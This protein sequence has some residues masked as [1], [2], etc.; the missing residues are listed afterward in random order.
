[1]SV[2]GFIAGPDGEMDWMVW[3]WDD[4]LKD[5]VGKITDTVDCIILGR[6][7]AEGFIP[8]WSS[9]PEEEG[10]E[11]I[12]SLPKIVFSKTLKQPAWENTKL[13][14][15]D[16][17]EEITRLKNLPGK[18]I[19]VY[20]G[21]GFVGNLIKHSLID[22]FHFLVNPTILGNG[23]AIFNNAALT[24]LQLKNAIGFECGISALNYELKQN[25]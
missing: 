21:A 6:K 9:H 5:Y 1:M 16:L 12:N 4:R 20:G 15:G 3:N 18:D 8:Y 24:N 19:I 22:E 17:V 14:T 10:A 23:M 13:A 7:L 11:M 2:D 25:D